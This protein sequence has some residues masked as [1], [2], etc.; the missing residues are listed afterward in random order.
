MTAAGSVQPNMSC[1]WAATQPQP[2]ME[3]VPAALTVP[4]GHAAQLLACVVR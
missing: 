2:W 3:G 1:V 4:A